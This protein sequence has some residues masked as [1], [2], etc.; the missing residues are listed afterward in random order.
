MFTTSQP[1]RPF[2][3]VGLITSA[4]GMTEGGDQK[5]LTLLREEAAKHGCD[6]VVVTGETRVASI[7]GHRITGYTARG[8]TGGYR[9]VCIVF[10]DGGGS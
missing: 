1:T 6:G 8:E 5:L 9:A 2:V 7:S 10:S 4:Q 3:E